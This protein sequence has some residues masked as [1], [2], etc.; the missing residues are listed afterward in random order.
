MILSELQ[1]IEK[2]RF[3]LEEFF[4]EAGLDK[5]LFNRVF[6]GLS[7]A[8]INSIVHGNKSDGNKAVFV[9]VSV[10]EGA[11]IIEVRDQGNGFSVDVVED[12][13]CMENLRKE[14]GR[15]IFLI[16][17]VADKL[18]YSH[19]GSNVIIKYHID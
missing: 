14:S 19:G 18:T 3:F 2:V 15:G 16:R 11:L 10:T 4:A 17:N 12:P 5:R 8:V 13:T 7:E 9:T 6:L 1:N